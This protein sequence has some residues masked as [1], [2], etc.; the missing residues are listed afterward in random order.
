M[1]VLPFLPWLQ[2]GGHHAEIG[3]A[4][5]VGGKFGGRSLQQAEKKKPLRKSA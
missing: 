1:D 2:S 5:R 4:I 3:F